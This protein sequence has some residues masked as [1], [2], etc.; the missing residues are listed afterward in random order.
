MTLFRSD[1]DTYRRQ[2]ARLLRY[3]SGYTEVSRVDSTYPVLTLSTN[4]DLSVVH[5]FDDEDTCF[6]LGGD[7]HLCSDDTHEFQILDE[8]AVFTGEFISTAARGVDVL[9]AFAEGSDL[10]GPGLWTRL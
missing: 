6:L 5:R 10:S 8:P 2:L 9:T 3:G 7:G 1:H 4:E